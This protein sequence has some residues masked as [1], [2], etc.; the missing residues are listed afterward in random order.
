VIDVTDAKRNLKTGWNK[1]SI[2]GGP[3]TVSVAMIEQA[4]NVLSRR[5]RER[6]S[7]IAA[8]CA[9]AKERERSL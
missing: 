5:I 9:L 1:K 4:L 2:V 7:T 6:R 8:D 3:L